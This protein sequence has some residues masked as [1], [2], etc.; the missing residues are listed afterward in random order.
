MY[1]LKDYFLLAGFICILRSLE[2][3][4]STGVCSALNSDWLW[5]FLS[6]FY[7][8]INVISWI[9]FNVCVF[10]QFQSTFTWLLITQSRQPSIQ[11]QENRFFVLMITSLE[12]LRGELFPKYLFA[13]QPVV[14]VASV[15][16]LIVCEVNTEARA[17][18]LYPTQET[19]ASQPSCMSPTLSE[20]CC[21]LFYVPF[22]LI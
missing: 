18:S 13:V 7:D 6:S 14:C 2:I 5:A 15:A 22:K 3:A 12:L 10:F 20:P 4:A 11:S 16:V 21:R 1:E 19:E 9:Y 17:F 8:W